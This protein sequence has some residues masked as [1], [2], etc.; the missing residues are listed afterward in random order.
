MHCPF[1]KIRGLSAPFAALIACGHEPIVE[2][3]FSQSDPCVYATIE[4]DS[5]RVE[6]Q[7]ELDALAGIT[8]ISGSLYVCY[9]DAENLTPLSSLQHVGGELVI[10]HNPRL[11]SLT[12]LEQLAEIGGGLELRQNDA[13]TTISAL[14]VLTTTGYLRILGND[15]LADVSMPT[16]QTIRHDLTVERTS[17]LRDLSGL[18]A[19]ITFGTPPLF[20]DVHISSNTALESLAGLEGVSWLE[21]LTLAGNPNLRSLQGL[22]GLQE[23]EIWALF[24][25][26][27]IESFAPLASLTRVGTIELVASRATSF[28][29]LEGVT[30][31]TGTL[32]VIANPLL[33][34]L[35]GLNNVASISRSLMINGNDALTALDQLSALWSVGEDLYVKRNATLPQCEAESLAARLKAVSGIGGD[36]IIDGNDTAAVCP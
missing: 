28:A 10:G 22:N 29:G 32:A 5:F 17:V 14:Q 7:S 30:E 8:E 12:G 33:Q 3:L 26:N 4:P 24:H 18:S 11:T 35:A 27:P 36:V 31:V 1:N 19:V 23:V 16:L 20:G 21:E 25:V 6:N 2:P 15:T 13:L 34:S 9:T